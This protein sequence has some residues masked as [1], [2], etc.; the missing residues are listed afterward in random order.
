MESVCTFQ[1]RAAEIG[2]LD[3]ENVS[4]CLNSNKIYLREIFE[5]KLPI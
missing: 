1:D 2:V 5:V 3:K 4:S